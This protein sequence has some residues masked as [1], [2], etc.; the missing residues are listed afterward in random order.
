MS[1]N[2]TDK[3]PVDTENRYRVTAPSQLYFKNIRSANYS[4]KKLPN[5]MDVYK[6]KKFST[7]NE[8]PIIYPTIIH[9]WM[10]DEAYIFIEKNAYAHYGDSLI[11]NWRQAESN[12][13]FHLALPTRDDQYDFVENIYDHIKKGDELFLKT[14]S[15]KDVPIFQN[16]EDRK[17][18]VITLNDYY[19]LTE[20]F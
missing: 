6:L 7:T 4:E 10:G 18:F 2:T 14:K 15:Q 20:R 16:L 8:R 13:Q 19:K 17:H 11:I 12:G 1:C 5:K 9:N 3:K